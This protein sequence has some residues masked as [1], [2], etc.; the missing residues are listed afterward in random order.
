MNFSRENKKEMEYVPIN[1]WPANQGLGGCINWVLW[2][3]RDHK[4]GVACSE[5][6][7]CMDF[8]EITR[9]RWFSVGNCR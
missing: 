7:E 8:N 6:Y 4:R 9:K 2:I 3:D 5:I 1:Q